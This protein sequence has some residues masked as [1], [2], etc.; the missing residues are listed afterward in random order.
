MLMAIPFTLFTPS[1]YAGGPDE[2]CPVSVD[3]YLILILCSRSFFVD[4]TSP[5]RFSSLRPLHPPVSLY[6]VV[7]KSIF[8]MM[9]VKKVRKARARL[10]GPR[11]APAHGGRVRPH[12]PPHGDES[13]R[14]SRLLARGH[15]EWTPVLLGKA[16]QRAARRGHH[17]RP[18]T[19]WF[20]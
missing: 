14:R 2:T 4:N 19:V 13:C 5:C 16:A 8:D 6:I 15:R 12:V 11:A 1:C 3:S 10:P 9:F 20:Y 7:G 17:V 18:L